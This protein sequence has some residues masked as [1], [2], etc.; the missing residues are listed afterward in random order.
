MVDYTKYVIYKGEKFR[1]FLGCFLEMVR[2][3]PNKHFRKELKS[4]LSK[5]NF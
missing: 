5:N 1:N 2:D 3:D 4:F